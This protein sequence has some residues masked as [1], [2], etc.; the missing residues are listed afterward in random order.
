MLCVA[1]FGI[2]YVGKD[3]AEHLLNALRTRYTVTT[4]WTGTI[5]L[6][7]KLKWN[8]KAGSVDLSM[9]GYIKEALKNFQHTVP[10]R[11]EDSSYPAPNTKWGT[12]SQFTAPKNK[13]KQIDAAAV[14]RLQQFVC[15]LLYY[16]QD[17]L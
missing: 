10:P 9:T 15:T 17:W 1:D 8:Y 14:N 7:I 4:D 6:E 3:H 5:F 12:D 11:Y 2:K 16:A 13:Y